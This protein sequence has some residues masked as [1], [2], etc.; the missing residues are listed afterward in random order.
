MLVHQRVFDGQKLGTEPIPQLLRP[1]YV[2][3]MEMPS[4]VRLYITRVA[5][6]GW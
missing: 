1:P 3:A 2:E 4:C 6:V 5:K